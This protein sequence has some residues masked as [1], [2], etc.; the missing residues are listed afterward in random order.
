M[1]NDEQAIQDILRQ[2]EAAW[3][4]SDSVGFAAAFAEDANFIQIFGG[5]LDGRGAIE[6]SHRSIFDTI[7]KDSRASFML[8]SIR[9]VRPDVAIVFTKTRVELAA[10]GA[11]P[12][13]E[14]RPTMV[15][16]KEQGK[17]QIMALQNT[18]ISEMPA[19]AQAASRLAT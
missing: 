11:T 2:L 5:Q 16:V 4:A 3:N 13:I 19:A 10:D 8:R 9:F 7:Y 17:W 18:K 14:A 6:A 15:V 1:T 12:E